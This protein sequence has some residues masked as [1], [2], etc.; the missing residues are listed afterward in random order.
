M[1]KLVGAVALLIVVALV[2]LAY[3]QL[4]PILTFIIVSAGF[5][6][7]ARKGDDS[8]WPDSIA[9]WVSG[10]GIYLGRKDQYVAGSDPDDTAD[11]QGPDPERR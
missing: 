2:A 3:L 4:S 5:Y 9:E 6:L 7:F 1:F 10:R 11:K 8:L